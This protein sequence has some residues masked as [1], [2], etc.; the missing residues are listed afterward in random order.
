M[1]TGDHPL[2]AYFIGKKLNI[3]SE[4]NEVAT[5]KDIDQKMELGEEV[6]DQYIKKIKVCARVTPMQKLAIVDS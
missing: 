5:G 6:F 3:I 2:T 1:I 4:Y